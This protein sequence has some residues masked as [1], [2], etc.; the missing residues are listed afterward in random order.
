MVFDIYRFERGGQQVYLVGQ[1]F[2]EFADNFLPKLKAAGLEVPENENSSLYERCAAITLSKLKEP[3]PGYM[4]LDDISLLEN[5]AEKCDMCRLVLFAFCT[6]GGNSPYS[7]SRSHWLNN[8]DRKNFPGLLEQL[9]L[10][11]DAGPASVYLAVT[12]AALSITI[13]G[14]GYRGFLPSLKVHA[15]PG[16]TLDTNHITYCC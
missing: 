14:G 4:L 12:G 10:R 2:C 9:D 13:K 6:S 5:S 16:L 15:Q 7:S 11:S 1:S 3:G 8:S